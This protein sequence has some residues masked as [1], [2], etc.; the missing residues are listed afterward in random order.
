M[1]SAEIKMEARKRAA[2]RLAE[3]WMLEVVWTPSRFEY[4]DDPDELVARRGVLTG[5]V[6]A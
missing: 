3:R 5:S 6:V 4:L 2:R 1:T